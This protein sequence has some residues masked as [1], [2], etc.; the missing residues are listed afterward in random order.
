M[1]TVLFA[2]LFFVGLA[3]VAWAAQTTVPHNPEGQTTER[4]PAMFNGTWR[5]DRERTRALFGVQAA[6]ALTEN[7]LA[8]LVEM[9]IPG[10]AEGYILVYYSEKMKDVHEKTPVSNAEIVGELL[11]LSLEGGVPFPL[12]II[13]SDTLIVRERGE[14]AVIVRTGP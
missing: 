3:P 9:R 7:N 4:D 13:D 6:E 11:V 2:L 1:R 8:G 12:Q 14:P 5:F 10:A